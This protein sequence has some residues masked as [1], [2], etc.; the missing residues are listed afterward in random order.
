MRVIKTLHLASFNGNVGDN[1]NHCGF[2]E[3]I[4][5]NK[6][7]K[8]EIYEL[9]IRDFY[10]KLRFFDQ[11][12]V[13]LVNQYDLLIVGGGNYFELWVED[14]PTGTSFAVEIELFSQI[15]TPIFFNA[16]GL[17]VGNGYSENTVEK[18]RNFLDV[19]ISK[20]HFISLRNDGAISSLKKYVGEKYL[21]YVK[22]TAD[23]GFLVSNKISNSYYKNKDYL[24]I[25]IASDMPHIRYK[26]IKYDNFV[27]QFK[28]FIES[29]LNKNLKYEI[30]LIP[31]I[32]RD[33]NFI[34]DILN[35]LD[36]RF[37]RE[38]I[39]VAPLLHGK[40]SVDDILSIYDNAKFVLANRF[41]ANVVSFA[42][43][44]PVI[45]LINYPQIKNL[46]EEIDVKYVVEMSDNFGESLLSMVD[47]LPKAKDYAVRDKVK[48]KYQEC[49]KSFFEWL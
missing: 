3:A 24:A 1:I 47:S 27:G 43:G 16:L 22:A 9:E 14:S 32:F 35:V 26:D 18:F 21:N 48:A 46:Y 25:N 17:D 13:D 39:N 36:D 31:H 19:A 29:F 12:F 8:F 38:R 20:N 41:H 44:T 11:S 15:K 23:A 5:E 49:I 10:R 42:L 2:Y 30:V 7:F 34:N 4:Q 40:E 37:V 6:D 28:Y 45:G 33:I